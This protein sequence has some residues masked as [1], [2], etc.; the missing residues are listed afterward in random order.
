L[1]DEERELESAEDFD[2]L[3]LG[4]PNSSIVWIQYMAFHLHAA[5][6]EKATAVGRRALKT[7]SFRY[8]H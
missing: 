2:R 8:G 7:I 6:I 1:L 4:S 5:E 3:V